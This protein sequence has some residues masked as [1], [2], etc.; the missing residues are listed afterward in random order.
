M[1]T[2]DASFRIKDVHICVVTIARI[3]DPSLLFSPPPFLCTIYKHKHPKSKSKANLC[4]IYSLPL[5][6]TSSTQLIHSWR[7]KGDQKSRKAPWL[8]G[9]GLKERKVASNGLS[10]QYR[11][12]ITPAS[13][14][15]LN[16]LTRFTGIIHP[17]RLSCHAQWMI[18]C[19]YGGR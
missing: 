13:I 9:S 19:I 2:R 17:A 5:N 11:T 3:K 6:T 4:L 10:Y 18:F 14:D 8:C 15:C 1:K 16:Q 12:Y 7:M